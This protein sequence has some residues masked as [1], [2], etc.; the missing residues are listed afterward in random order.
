MLRVLTRPI[1]VL[2]AGLL[3]VVGIGVAL[4]VLLGFLMLA[5]AIV[6]M[7]RWVL[8]PIDH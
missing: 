4:G 7:R 5:M 6:Y 8:L 2:R 3:V 1:R